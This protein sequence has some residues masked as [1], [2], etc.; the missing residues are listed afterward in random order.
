MSPAVEVRPVLSSRD[1]EQFIRFP[2]QLYRND[3]YWVPPLLDERRK[4]L[5]PRH[6][7]FFDHADVALWLAWR[8]GQV[9]G[10][11]SSH[12]DHLHN[13]VHEEKT[14][15]FGFFETVDD[16]QV[17]EALLTTARDW[18]RSKG[19]NALRGPLSFSQNHEV[20]MLLEGEP[21]PPMVMM[22]Y[23]PPYYNE[24]VERFGLTKVM[25]VYAYVA[26]LSQFH[27]DPS[28]LPEKLVR[29]TNLAKERAGIVTR[30]PRMKDFD[31]ELQRAK[32]VYNQA[33]VRNWGF[34]PM[35]DAEVDKLA[36]DLK[37]ILD[38]RLC[39]IVEAGER[40]VGLS[41]CVPDVNQVLKH[42][43]GRLFPLGWLKALWYARKITGARLMIMGVV[44][45]FRGH[46]VEAVLMYET[47]RSAIESGYTAIEFSWILETNEM[48]NR[49]IVKVGGPYGARRYRTY[50]IYQMPV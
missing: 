19:M 20:G 21:G 29:V 13:Q 50:R 16:Y 24:F 32:Q 33:W 42:L 10:T 1:L 38:P 9:V 3:P 40:P 35:T 26:D 37:Q 28:G 15:M 48:M 4:F 36:G 27:G 17:A 5:S 49:I 43:N 2:F 39:V 41:V 44:E 18:V 8:N 47:V 46:G 25:D 12:V 30:R 45:D 31:A 14:G 34:V 11:I 6:N 22:P 7:P 23:N